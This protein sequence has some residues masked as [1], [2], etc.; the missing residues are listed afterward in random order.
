MQIKIRNK[1]RKIYSDDK[2]VLFTWKGRRRVKRSCSPK[3]ENNGNEESGND[4]CCSCFLQTWF[5]FMVKLLHI[6]TG[7]IILQG[8]HALLLQETFFYF[9]YIFH[10]ATFC[11]TKII[12]ML[13]FNFDTHIYLIGILYNGLN[14]RRVEHNLNKILC[15]ISSVF[16]LVNLCQLATWKKLGWVNPTKDFLWKNDWM[17]PYF[18]LQYVD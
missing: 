7:W 10:F 12:C 13:I 5:S 2:E 17:F 9:I 15:I 4:Y 11:A 8:S 1:S 16:C 6:N 3:K 18:K 14:K